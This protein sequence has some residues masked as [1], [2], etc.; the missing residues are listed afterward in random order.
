MNKLLQQSIVRKASITFLMLV[1]CT[2][3]NSRD[4]ITDFQSSKQSINN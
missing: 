3:A 2:S 1:S 4:D